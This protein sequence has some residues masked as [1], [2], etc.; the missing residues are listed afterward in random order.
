MLPSSR[1][2]S[3]KHQSASRGTASFA[4]TPS[5]ASKSSEPA[6]S[7]AASASASVRRR[8]ASISVMSSNVSTATGGRP[9]GTIV[10]PEATSARVPDGVSQSTRMF[11]NRS[12]A[13]TRSCSGAPASI[14][15]APPA[16]A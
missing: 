12:P 3:T 1:S 6:S 7:A 16:A 9:G 13:A 2:S 5:V 14:G 11:V 15:N 10:S 8:A 4:I